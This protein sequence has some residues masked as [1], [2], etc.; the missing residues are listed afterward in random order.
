M[1][2]LKRSMQINCSNRLIVHILVIPGDEVEIFKITNIIDR[3][4]SSEW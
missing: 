1:L 3:N 2:L 4:I